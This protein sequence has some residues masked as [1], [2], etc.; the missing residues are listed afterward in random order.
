VER[1][2]LGIGEEVRACLSALT[3]MRRSPASR[4]DES[5]TL[6]CPAVFEMAAK[7]ERV[8]RGV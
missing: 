6:H 4:P 2:A 5:A 1:I 3:S 7:M 8:G